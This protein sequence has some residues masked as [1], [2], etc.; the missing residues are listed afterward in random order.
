[1][2]KDNDAKKWEHTGEGVHGGSKRLGGVEVK[3]RE[4]GKR[5]IKEARACK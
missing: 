4:E 3:K 1:M 5:R 2:F